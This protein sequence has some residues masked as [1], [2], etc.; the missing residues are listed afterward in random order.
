MTTLL[1]SRAEAP[2][3]HQPS[4][5]ALHLRSV[6]R[7]T[8]RLATWMENSDT[9]TTRKIC[10]PCACSC[11]LFI[12]SLPELNVCFSVKSFRKNKHWQPPPQA[13]AQH[14]S[15]V[16]FSSPYVQIC[17]CFVFVV[18]DTLANA[19]PATNT[20]AP[21]HPS[22]VMTMMPSSRADVVLLT[23]A[24]RVSCVHTRVGPAAPF[25]ALLLRC[26]LA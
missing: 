7:P 21:L 18:C 12:F 19:G 25:N 8:S 10:L 11:L 2:K 9:T 5:L 20:A 16:E 13:R 23:T 17:V 24:T 6:T 26:L 15:A 22:A 1:Q 3:Q 14:R 4:V